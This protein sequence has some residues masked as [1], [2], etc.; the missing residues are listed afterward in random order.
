MGWTHQNLQNHISNKD[1]Y[2][3]SPL[4]DSQERKVFSCVQ[5]RLW[6]DCID[7]QADLSCCW[8]HNISRLLTKPTKWSVRP[9]K[10]QVSLG[11]RPVWS[12]SSLCTQWVAKD[13][14]FLHADSEDSD[15]TGH[16]SLHWEHMPFGWFCHEAA[17]IL[18]C[19]LWLGWS[20]TLLLFFTLFK[21]ATR[22]QK[23]VYDTASKI[24]ICTLLPI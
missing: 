21:I 15:Q 7:A 12:E 24:A 3:L 11:I 19:S 9:A 8:T 23:W 5:Q 13:L 22:S 20:R 4:Q 16:L 10:T 2:Q 14:S 18:Q 6:S 1:S 17:H